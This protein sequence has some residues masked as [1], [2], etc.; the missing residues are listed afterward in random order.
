MNL[1]YGRKD[2]ADVAAKKMVEVT[3]YNVERNAWTRDCHVE[4]SFYS[5]VGLM[6]EFHAFTG[7]RKDK[8]RPSKLHAQDRHGSMIHDVLCETP[9]HHVEEACPPMGGHGDQV[10]IHTL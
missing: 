4:C 7:L 9:V 3:Y 8:A 6:Q 1:G 2:L 5:L 10:S